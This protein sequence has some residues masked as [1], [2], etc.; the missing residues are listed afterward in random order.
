M[1]RESDIRTRIVKEIKRRGGRPIKYYGCVYTEAGV[2]DL[3][4]CYRGLFLVIET[5]VPGETVTPKQEAFIASVHQSGG[6]GGQACSVEEALAY[7]DEI[8]ERVSSLLNVAECLVMEADGIGCDRG[9]P[10]GAGD[11]CDHCMYL[12][13]AATIKKCLTSV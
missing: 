3:L 1:A 9:N 4:V 10:N 5:K 11:E 2:S 6:W 7:L 8:D 13:M 12:G